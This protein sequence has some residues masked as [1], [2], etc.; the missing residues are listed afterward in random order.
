MG[1]ILNF[2]QFCAQ[3]PI[4]NPK[5]EKVIAVKIIKIAITKGYFI[6]WVT[7]RLDVRKIIKPIIVDFEAAAPT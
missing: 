3:I 1:I 4:I 5:R 2:S 6:S 7:N